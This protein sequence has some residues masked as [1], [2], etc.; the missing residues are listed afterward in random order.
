[1]ASIAVAAWGKCVVVFLLAL[2][3]ASG[4]N[5]NRSIQASNTTIQVIG[6]VNQTFNSTNST[7]N[8]SNFTGLLEEVIERPSP[9]LTLAGGGLVALCAIISA[10]QC[11]KWLT[12]PKRTPAPLLADTELTE[13]DP[14]HG[15]QPTSLWMGGNGP[16][17]ELMAE[18][19][20]FTQF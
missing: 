13:G 8:S 2:Q 15:D 3:L 16:A 9:I 20:G 10:W 19:A 7:S 18:S 11:F 4:D 17:R 1:M 14:V 12:G 5:Q 6:I